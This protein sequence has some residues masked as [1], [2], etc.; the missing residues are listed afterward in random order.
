M[1]K[2]LIIGAHYDDPELAAGGSIAKWVK[3]SKEVYKVILTD[4][5]TNFA[6]RKIF[7][8]N[9]SSKIESVKSCKILGCKEIEEFPLQPCTNLLFNK[10]QMQ[11]I[12]SFILDKNI[13]TV[14]LHNL[15]DI[16]QDHVN[17]AT[18]SYVAGRYCDNILTYQSNKY[19]LPLDFYPRF[20]V[21]ITDTIEQKK[22]ALECYGI[23]HNRYSNLFDITIQQNR[24]W[25]YQINMNN[26]ETYAEAFGIIKF[27]QR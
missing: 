16:Q 5:V 17:A 27:V 18:I 2:I 12:E 3:E 26:K 11:I 14:I 9:K 8:D 23:S 7:V 24:V 1:N 6:K 15:F 22:R 13:D 10:K 25:G 19:V 20:F 21:D 4:N